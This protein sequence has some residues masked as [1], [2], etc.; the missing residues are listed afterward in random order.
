MTEDDNFPRL[1]ELIVS[2]LNVKEHQV[3]PDASFENDLKADSLD[4]V[5][6]VMAFEDHFQIEIDDTIGPDIQ[7]VQDALNYINMNQNKN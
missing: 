3:T 6:L 1:R 2:Q 7:T 4:L 5:E